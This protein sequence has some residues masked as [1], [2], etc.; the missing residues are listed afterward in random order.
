MQVMADEK[1]TSK[2][3]TF[4]VKVW[5]QLTIADWGTSTPHPTGA[6]VISPTSPGRVSSSE[7]KPRVT[8]VSGHSVVVGIRKDVRSE[9]NSAIFRSRE[10][11]TCQCY[12]NVCTI[13]LY[14]H[15]AYVFARTV[16]RLVKTLYTGLCGKRALVA[17]MT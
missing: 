1:R 2:L 9:Q 6:G 4:E 16:Y 13:L 15:Y 3:N 8:S 5:F 14:E 17:R 7:P 10:T 11:R 12:C